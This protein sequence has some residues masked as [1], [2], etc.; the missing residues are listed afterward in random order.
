[1]PGFGGGEEED[2][3]WFNEYEP[4]PDLF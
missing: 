1:M 2:I 3:E 4:A